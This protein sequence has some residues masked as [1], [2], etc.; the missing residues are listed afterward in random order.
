[1]KKHFVIFCSP[2][3]FTSETSEYE[4]E[5]WDVRVAIEKSKGIT[6]RWNAKPYGFYFVTR[7]RT[8][9][10]LNSKIIATSNMYYLGGTVETYD[11]V[12]A[13]NDPKEEILRSNMQC[14]NWDKILVNTNSYKFTTYLKKG[15]IVLNIVNGALVSKTEY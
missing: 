12:C 11:E 3:S 13:R 1:V 14:N 8:E 9:T 2:G 4:V 5:S 10:E 7:G 15:D 6:E